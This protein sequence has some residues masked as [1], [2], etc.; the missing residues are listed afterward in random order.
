MKAGS[1]LKNANRYFKYVASLEA[2][3]F[4]ICGPEAMI[5][6]IRD[7][8]VSKSIDA[9]KIHFELFNTNTSNASKK[10]NSAYYYIRQQ[11]VSCYDK[12][13][14]QKFSC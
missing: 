4:F 8:L 14:R 9:K 2:D 1:L 10:T 12:P 5:F 7:W 13:R 3:A 6:S 11:D